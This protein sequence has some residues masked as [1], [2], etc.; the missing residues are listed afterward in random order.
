M[1]FGIDDNAT[2]RLRAWM[3]SQ[4]G[5]VAKFYKEVTAHRKS[6]QVAFFRANSTKFYGDGMTVDARDDFW[7]LETFR[8]DSRFERAN[9]IKYAKEG[10]YVYSTLP[11]SS[12]DRLLLQ[13]WAKASDLLH[14]DFYMRLATFRR[15]RVIQRVEAT[16]MT[17]LERFLE[18]NHYLKE[19]ER[20]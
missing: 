1:C 18:A 9:N 19:R 7:P 14:V 6:P 13:V 3:E 11:A 17:H 8:Q 2:N 5:K 12:G 4:P 20:G 10:I 16:E 15:V